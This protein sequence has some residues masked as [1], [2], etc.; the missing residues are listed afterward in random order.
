MDDTKESIDLRRIRARIAGTLTLDDG[1]IHEALQMKS[2]QYRA[3]RTATAEDAT[4]RIFSIARELVP[5]M[6]D[7]QFGQLTLDEA[8]AIIA[9]AS[10]GIAMVGAIFPNVSSP[11]A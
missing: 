11:D 6:S 7:E 4:D 8:N 1:T 3:L 2:L 10:G 9:F 5:T